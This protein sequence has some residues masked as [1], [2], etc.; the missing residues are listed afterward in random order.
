M[1]QDKDY[2]EKISVHYEP[3]HEEENVVLEDY[4]SAEEN[5]KM[6]YITDIFT[7]FQKFYR[8]KTKTTEDFFEGIDLDNPTSTNKQT[9]VF[10]EMMYEYNTKKQNNDTVITVYNLDENVPEHQH[11][12]YRL[13]VNDKPRLASGSLFSIFSEMALYDVNW[14]T[15]K[16]NIEK[17]VKQS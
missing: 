11:G 2:A 13:V 16:W 8:K 15:K 3:E 5:E 7:L 6:K 9:E 4:V 10:Y 1:D 14:D 17:M 12:C